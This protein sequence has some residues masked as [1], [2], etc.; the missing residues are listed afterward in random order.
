MAIEKLDPFR[1]FYLTWNYH[2]ILDGEAVKLFNTVS[3]CG[4]APGKTGGLNHESRIMILVF[5][6]LYVN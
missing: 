6:H 5:G 2:E 3:A 1:V 4:G